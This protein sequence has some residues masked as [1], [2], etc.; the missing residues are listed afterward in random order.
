MKDMRGT[1]YIIFMYLVV[2]LMDCDEI[3]LVKFCQ[4]LLYHSSQESILQF[5]TA[6]RNGWTDGQADG[7][8]DGQTLLLCIKCQ[9]HI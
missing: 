1:I 9:E 2:I 6:G 3:P 8:M 7:Q 5:A 4:N